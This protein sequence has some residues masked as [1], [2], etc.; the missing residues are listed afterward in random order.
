MSD[1]ESDYNN[2]FA[3]ILDDKNNPEH[4]FNKVPDANLTINNKDFM[5]LLKIMNNL[6]NDNNALKIELQSLRN[7][8]NKLKRTT[9]TTNTTT[10]TTTIPNQSDLTHYIDVQINTK[11]LS[12]IET[13]DKKISDVDKKINTYKSMY[14]KRPK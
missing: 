14:M 2:D 1:S 12:I 10:Q 6:S 11:L 9:N 4:I 8:V 3:S 13:F 7:D 5:K